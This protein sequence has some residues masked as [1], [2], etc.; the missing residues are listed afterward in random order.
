MSKGKKID[1][2]KID[3][4]DLKDKSSDNPGLISFPHSIGSAVIKPEDKGKIKGRAMAAM[5]EQTQH[6]LHQLYEQMRTLAR[7]ANGIKNR[8][9]VSERIYQAQMNYE[10]RI[11]QIYHLYEKENDNDLLSMIS[12][13]EWGKD[14]PFKSFIASVRLLSDH[15]WEVL[16]S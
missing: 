5:K 8:V 14:M 3:L 11:G 6:Q 4:E 1:P 2:N 9:K 7:Q 16:D 10:P 15:T 12:P 13:D